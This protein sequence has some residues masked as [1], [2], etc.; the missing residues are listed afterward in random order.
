MT[1]VEAIL[2]R[3]MCPE[4]GCQTLPVPGRAPVADIRCCSK[5]SCAYSEKSAP[6][7]LS[8]NR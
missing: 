4:Q 2:P 1:L 6:L 3:V 7:M 5:P 8:G